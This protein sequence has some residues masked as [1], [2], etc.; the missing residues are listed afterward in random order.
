MTKRV[1]SFPITSPP[2]SHL[3]ES[4]SE[5]KKAEVLADNLE[6]QIQPVTDPSGPAFVETF[7]VGQRSYCMAPAGEPKLTIP[8]E[9]QEAIRGLKVSKAPGPNGI[10]NRTFKHHP[11]RAI[12]LL[13]LTFN[14]ILLTHHFPTAWKHVRLIFIVNPGKDPALPFSYHPISLMDKICKLF[15]K[16]LL[17]RN[18]HEVNVRG[19]MQDE[20][21]GYRPKHSTSVYL[22]RLV[23]RITR[24]FGE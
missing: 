8:D 17:A 21:F 12:S 23:A 7:D 16:L 1:I 11:K 14:A 20:Q 3:G 6:T 9:V 5:S 2:W 22:A 19:M 4:L 24:T 18:L 10:P 13:V 15:E